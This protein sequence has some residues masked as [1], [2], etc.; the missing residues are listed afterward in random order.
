MDEL[1]G[2]PSD[3]GFCH[4]EASEEE[5]M[6]MAPNMVL[7]WLAYRGW[8]PVGNSVYLMHPD[9]ELSENHCY[10][11]SKAYGLELDRWY[12]NTVEKIAA[13]KP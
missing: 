12:A 1:A 3:V 6:D 8:V 11:V 10:T 9:I 2:P 13:D 4:P 7:G 5:I